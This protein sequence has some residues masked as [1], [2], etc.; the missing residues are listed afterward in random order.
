LLS[1]RPGLFGLAVRLGVPVIPVAIGYDPPSLAWVGDATF[2]PHYLTLASRRHTRAFVRFGAPIVPAAN[3]RALD[4]ARAVH[5]E[6]AHLLREIPC[7][8]RPPSST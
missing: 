5:G 6:V 1:F 8:S 3:A 2:L 7:P 4:L